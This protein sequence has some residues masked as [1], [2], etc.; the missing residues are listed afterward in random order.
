MT[1]VDTKPPGGRTATGSATARAGG[2]PGRVLRRLS[3]GL[4][5]LLLAACG[6]GY[7]Y[8]Q[9]L[10]A[11]FQAGQR[12]L[13]EADG[14]R[15]APN[16]AGQTPL[17]ILLIG[18]DNRGSAKNV[19]LGGS[20]D[21]AG[22]PGLA[23][24]QMLLHVSADRSNASLVSIP[25]DTLVD[26]P[27][28]K[29]E[30]G[31]QSYPAVSKRMINEALARGGPGCLVGTWAKLTNLYVDHYMM[32]DFAG[33]V[34]MAD[35]VG[36]V[37]VCVN[38][39]LYDR[40]QPKI[41]GTGLKLPKGTSVVK[42]E[43]ALQWLRTRDA[44]GDD[45]G[46]TKAQHL[47]L[48]SMVRELKASG[49]LGDPAGLMRLAETASRSISLDKDLADLKR[50]YDLGSDLRKVPTERITTLTAPTVTAPSDENR[51]EL[52]QPDSG[53]IWQL[54]HADRPLDG[55]GPAT[56]GSAPTAPA[57]P[58]AAPDPSVSA[59]SPATV[60]IAVQNASGVERRATEV[61]AALAAKGFTEAATTA[62]GTPR[63]TTR[64]SYPPAE[65][66]GARAVAAALG[67]PQSALHEGGAKAELVLAI[68]ADWP[69]GTGFPVATPPTGLPRSAEAVTAD[70]D[71]NCMTV[72]PQG[73]TYTY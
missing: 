7:W 34:D 29:S 24:V 1:N 62:N 61:R 68:G 69:S 11:N 40:Y 64:L 56:G 49:T 60:A 58:S 21:D 30:D 63:E 35:A 33:V 71:R 72:N 25:R 66:A 31:R 36:G 50:L 48:S 59:V 18:T 5:F 73:G 10:N 37:P 14:A 26:I 6:G 32:I 45:I 44:W 16:A 67:L 19:A 42:G 22:R 54:L 51:L 13:S 2:R 8:Y 52:K 47:Y 65:A 53:Q 38:M 57:P 41:G 43:Q 27:A 4:A 12:N 28:C 20:A 46:R 17:N 55:K 23:D 15:T 70:D 9:H 39:N 3:L